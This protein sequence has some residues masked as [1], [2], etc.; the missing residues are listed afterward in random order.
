MTD[1][2]EQHDIN[3]PQET[4]E[5][6]LKLKR[7]ETRKVEDLRHVLSTAQ[8]RRVIAKIMQDCG[9]FMSFN[10]LDTSAAQRFLGAREVGLI[11][12]DECLVADKKALID[13]ILGDDI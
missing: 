3:D 2:K 6:E 11:L 9:T 8:G 1:E 10:S 4:Y 12:K 13:I 5:R 7:D